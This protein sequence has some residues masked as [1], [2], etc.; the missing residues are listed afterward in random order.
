VADR[1]IV[2]G[3]DAA[4][5]SAAASARRRDPELEI[6][7][8]ERGP[9][10]SYSA[11]GIP[12]FVGGLFG[13]ADRLI[14]RTPGEFREAGIDVRTRTEAIAI[15]LDGRTVTVRDLGSGS[16]ATSASTS[17]STRPARSR[18]P[19]RSPARRSAS[20]CALSTRRS[21]SGRA[22]RRPKPGMLW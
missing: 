22:S 9:H 7:A 4:G 17:S 5:M 16:R 6:V 18:S 11:C 15:D 8:L 13:D 12:Y 1:L 20:R 2:I 21:A 10:T 3:G 19:R 14:S